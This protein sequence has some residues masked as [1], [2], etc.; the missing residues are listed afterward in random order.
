MFRLPPAA[1]WAVLCSLAVPAFGAVLPVTPGESTSGIQ[2]VFSSAEPGD[3]VSFA[4]GTYNIKNLLEVPCGVTITGPVATP[5]TAVLAASY[6]GNNIFSLVNCS[7]PTTIEYLHFENTGGIYVTAPSSGLT[8]THNQFTNLPANYSQFTDMGV[9]F[10]GT[11]GGTIANA[12]I[13]N[14]TIGDA[15]SCTAVMSL[16]SDEGG[17]CDG[18]VFQGNL[19]GIA[20]ENNEFTHL[21]EGFHV[22]CYGNNCAGPTAPTWTHFDAKWNDFN[23]IHRIAMEMQPQNATDV[24]IQYNTYENAYAPSTFSMGISLACCAGISGATVPYANDN[25]LLANTP[26]AGEYIAFAIEWWGNGAQANNNLIQGY[27]AN[28][29]VWG[30]GGPP[31][32]VLNTIIEGPNM[33]G[34]YG[35]FICNEKEGATTIP[36]QSGNTTSTTIMPVDSVAPTISQSSGSVALS[37]TGSNTSIY[38]TTDGSTPT[39]ASTLYTGPFSPAPGSTVRAIGMWGQGANAKTFPAGYGYLPSA[40]VTAVVSGVSSAPTVQSIS[41]TGA[42]SAT[43][44]GATLQLA[45]VATYSDGSQEPITPTAWSSNQAAVCTVSPTGLVT[46]VAAGACGVAASFESLT[47][48]PYTI[49]VAVAP[50]KVTSLA[51]AVTATTAEIGATLQFTATGVYSNGTSGPVV[52]AWSSSNAAVATISATGLLTAVAEGSVQVNASSGGVSSAVP[53]TIIITSGGPIVRGFL[54]TPGNINTLAPCGR[55]QFS[56][57]AEY[58]D[59]TT[60]SVTP[61][62]WAT[63]NTVIGTISPTGLFTANVPGTVNVVA[64]LAGNVS[65]S[66][67]GITIAPS[68]SVTIPLAPGTYT[69]V[70]PACGSASITG[71]GLSISQ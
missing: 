26:P 24:V 4:A 21:E 51:L 33:G 38:Y 44:G 6:T 34:R 30:K 3:T 13:T 64:L 32:E 20:I 43:L 58:A 46:P 42:T 56:A 66:Q 18:L 68:P 15:N 48:A 36:M 53:I 25:V 59:G 10:D 22:L 27:W 69:V 28:G 40:V 70:I 14:N 60:V 49:S 8:I 55:L 11:S 35:C 16:N 52:A 19:N 54:S 17:D 23:N 61:V 5:A 37:D 45:A 7:R 63:T 12:T 71:L 41:V 1:L 9:Y 31:W 65:S 67:W 39:T 62:S 57:F 2:A 50:P 29:I 47:S